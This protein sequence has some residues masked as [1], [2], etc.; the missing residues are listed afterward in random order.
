MSRTRQPSLRLLSLDVAG[1]RSETK[2]SCPEL[3]TLAVDLNFEDTALTV[4]AVYVPSTAASRPHFYRHCL[5]PR[6]PGDRILLLS[7]DRYLHQQLP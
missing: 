6:L 4:I 1:P 7:G 5:L 3:R 2:R